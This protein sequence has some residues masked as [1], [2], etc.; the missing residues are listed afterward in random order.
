MLSSWQQRALLLLVAIASVAL[1]A[2]PAIGANGL[3]PPPPSNVTCTAT[4]G[5]TICRAAFTTT[6]SFPKEFKCGSGSSA[7]YV[8]E[9]GTTDRQVVFVYDAAGNLTERVTR[10]TSLTGAFT[11]ATTGRSLSESGHFT[12]THEF[13]TPGDLSTDQTTFDGLFA[14]VLV[15]GTGIVLQD[16]GTIVYA[17]DGDVLKEG[18]H[19]Q[20][21]ESDLA[22]ICA[23]L[24]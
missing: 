5:G 21:Q 16:A 2:S 17:P 12:I 6:F 9:A 24:A 11:N 1:V 20:Y 7:F 13:L 23:A 4:G 22:Q 14:V 18:G 19:H 8:N 10:V 3:N 15:P